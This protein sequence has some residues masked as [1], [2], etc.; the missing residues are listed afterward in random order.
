MSQVAADALQRRLVSFAV[1]IIERVGHFP[2]L[3]KP[4]SHESINNK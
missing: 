3:L 2:G 4:K 1:R